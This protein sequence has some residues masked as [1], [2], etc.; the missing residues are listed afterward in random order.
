MISLMTGLSTTRHP[1]LHICVLLPWLL[2]HRGNFDVL[3][4]AS[5]YLKLGLAL[6]PCLVMGLALTP[7]LMMGLALYPYE[8]AGFLFVYQKK[9]NITE[10]ISVAHMS[11]MKLMVS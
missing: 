6:I 3:M 4:F 7:Y 11:D 1:K 9:I 2:D 5:L 8:E 10:G